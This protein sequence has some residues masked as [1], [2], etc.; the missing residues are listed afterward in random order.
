MSALPLPFQDTPAPRTTIYSRL[1]GDLHIDERSL[2]TFTHGLLGMPLYQ[3][4]ALLRGDDETYWLQ[5]ADDRSLAL[6]LV[7]P[8]HYFPAYELELGLETT[9]A[10]DIRTPADA[11][12]LA[13]VTLDGPGHGTANLRGPLV[14]NLA[15]RRAMQVV[16]SAPAEIRAPFAIPYVSASSHRTPAR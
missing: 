14:F 9:S 11:L 12:V 5:S 16:I 1:L 7:D 4:F 2:M 3:R 6:M 10:L 13:V 8:F 15:S